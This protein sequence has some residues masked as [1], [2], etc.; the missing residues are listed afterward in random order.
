LANVDQ[1]R[2]RASIE[3]WKVQ[4]GDLVE[5]TWGFGQTSHR[6]V[7]AYRCLRSELAAPDL[8]I[9]ASQAADVRTA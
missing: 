8:E 5:H 2:V 1:V 9:A 7:D 4:A 6:P 3:G